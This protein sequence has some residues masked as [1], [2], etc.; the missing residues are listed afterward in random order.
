MPTEGFVRS[1]LVTVF[2]NPNASFPKIDL[3]LGIVRWWRICS[4]HRI[5]LWY[6]ARQSSILPMPTEGF[7]SASSS[8]FF[9]LILLMLCPKSENWA[10]ASSRKG[11]TSWKFCQIL[12]SE[13]WRCVWRESIHLKYPKSASD[14]PL[15]QLFFWIKI[16]DV[17]ARRN[18]SVAVPEI[19]V[20]WNLNLLINS[21]F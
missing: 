14:Q 20:T 19:K 18:A 16:V 12:I 17:P 11:I 7:V 2:I 3:Y 5:C 10:A 15:Q 9:S 13:Q 4:G 21:Q 8:T 1:S 6:M